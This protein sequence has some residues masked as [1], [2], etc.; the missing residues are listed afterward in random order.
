MQAKIS[1]IIWLYRLKQLGFV[2]NLSE[3]S[4]YE[5]AALDLLDRILKELEAKEIEDRMKRWH[6]K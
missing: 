4:I 2:F 1:Y 5:V 6:M 3:M